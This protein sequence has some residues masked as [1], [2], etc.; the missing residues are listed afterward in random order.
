[1]I[2]R[3]QAPLPALPR[4]AWL[5]QGLE[6]RPDLVGEHLGLLPGREVPALLGLV[7]V[8]EGGIAQLD[9]AARGPEDLVRE[10]READRDRDVRRSMFRRLRLGPAALPVRPGSRR[11]AAGQPVQRD[12]VD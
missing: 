6:R 3:W 1:M 12:V 7:E 5:A 2:M 11:P 10:G 4:R 8:A 9:P